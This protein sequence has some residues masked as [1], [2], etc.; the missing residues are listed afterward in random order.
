MDLVSTP[1]SAA[2]YRVT[3]LPLLQEQTYL[4]QP[5]SY[6]NSSQV[7]LTPPKLLPQVATMSDNNKQTNKQY[8]RMYTC[9]FLHEHLMIYKLEMLTSMI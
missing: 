7:T 4:M 5:W 1:P 6:W 3:P 2:N 8:K 9:M